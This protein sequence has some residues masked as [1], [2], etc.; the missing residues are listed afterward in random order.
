MHVALYIGRRTACYSG[1]NWMV[2]QTEEVTWGSTV[3]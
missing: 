3:W 1:M 2:T